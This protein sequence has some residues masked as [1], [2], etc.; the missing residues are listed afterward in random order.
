MR[1]VLGCAAVS[2]LLA[3]GCEREPAQD[4]PG[5]ENGSGKQGAA[6]PRSDEGWAPGDEDDPRAGAPAEKPRVPNVGCDPLDGCTS[7][8]PGR[9]ASCSDRNGGC[10]DPAHWACADVSGSAPTCSDIDEC[11]DGN[12]GCEEACA[13]S[14]GAYACACGAGLELD[15]DGLTCRGWG[16]DD[17]LSLTADF[18]HDVDLAADSA[19]NALVV[20]SG[21]GGDE[22][23][24]S[25][26]RPGIGWDHEFI[27]D[28]LHDSDSWQGGDPDTFLQVAMDQAGNAFVLWT[29]NNFGAGAPAIDVAV[30]RYDKANETWSELT[31]IALRARAA[32]SYPP[33][34]AVGATGDAYVTWQQ[35]DGAGVRRYSAADGRW[36][37]AVALG[38][39]SSL[40]VVVA[41]GKGDGMVAWSTGTATWAQRYGARNGWK[42]P[43]RIDAGSAG[44][45]QLASDAAG[46]I[47]ALW[48]AGTELWANRYIAGS[49][50][51]AAQQ[52]TGPSTSRIFSPQLA[53]GEGGTAVVA[54]L[55]DG[56]GVWAIDHDGSAWS[57]AARVHDAPPAPLGKMQL[58]VDGQGSAVVLWDETTTTW[59]SSRTATGWS[60]P[61]M[62]VGF[63]EPRLVAGA[64]KTLLVGGYDSADPTLRSHVAGRWSDPAEAIDRHPAPRPPSNTGSFGGLTVVSARATRSGQGFFLAWVLEDDYWTPQISS[65]SE[66]VHGARYE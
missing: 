7:P 62:V 65:T 48:I 41:D 55:T 10:G 29:R 59:T 66:F 44:A 58:A 14:V 38:P 39:D 45:P 33:R 52:L 17:E 49:G 11:A 16:D 8:P 50:W 36:K 37:D 56:E 27:L 20:W 1:A 53:I 12:G 61:E 5:G 23:W 2:V 31:E 30:K 40:A 26:Y 60:A 57:D 32:Q 28:D 35:A 47:V 3:W 34:L 22:V 24:A 19:G 25:R 46:N 6:E 21:S 4:D 9:T 42:D 64:S 51:E 63:Q 18:I 54:W 15:P 13:N 43:V